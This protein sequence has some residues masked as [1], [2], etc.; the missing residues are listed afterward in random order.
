MTGPGDPRK[1]QIP[2]DN[3]EEVFKSLVEALPDAML[4]HSADRIVF[5]N[6]SCVKLI[7][8]DS[9]E[10]L[11]G[12]NIYDFV[13][14]SF[15]AEVQRRNLECYEKGTT[16]SPSENVLLALDG[17]SVPTEFTAT[18]ISWHGSPA[19]E[20]VLRN[21]RGRKLA[22]ET[23]RE[24]ERIV[25]G[26]Q[27]MIA[28]IDREYRFV[29]AN[30]AFLDYRCLTKEQVI[31]HSVLDLVDRTVFQ[32]VMK[33][34]L[35][36]CFAGN[37]VKYELRNT[38]P[39]LGE[40]DL[41][42]S[43]FPIENAGRVTGAAC[44]L[45]DV[46]DRKRKAREDRK[47][48]KR[49]EL[50]EQAGLRLGLWDW[51]LT[52]NTVFWSDESYRQSGFAPG[53]FSER[54][55]DA[56]RRVHPDDQ[57]AVANAIERVLIHG[58]S[59]YKA[60]YRLLR[61]D[62]AIRWIDA[63][64]VVLRGDAAHMIGVA[65][66]IT[67]LKKTEQSLKESEEQYLLLLNSTAEAIH[68]LDAHGNCTFCNPA[69]FRLLGYS[70]ADD[71]IGRNMHEVLHHS[72]ADGVPYPEEEC[73]IYKAFRQ[74]RSSHVT[75][76]VFWRLDGTSFP[77][78]C[79]SY[80]MWKD[81][82]IIGSVVTFLDISDRQY[83]ES[84][85]RQSEE[86]YRQLFENAPYGIYHSAFDGTLLD[87]NTAL[88]AML[89]YDSKEELMSRN[90]DHDIYLDASERRAAIER[91]RTEDRVEGLEFKWKRRDGKVIDVRVSGRMIQPDDGRTPEME[92]IVD[93]ITGRKSL[94]QQLRQAQKMESVGRLAG[95]IAHDFNNLLMVIQS[96]TELLQD[97]LPPGDILRRRTHEVMKA[98]GRAATTS[99]QPQ[100]DHLPRRAQ[101]ECRHHR[102]REDVEA[103]HR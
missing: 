55:E 82:E 80:P 18:L 32:T 98:T 9:P 94:Q 20:V 43:Y 69:C 31:G 91:C 2:S 36:E 67:N 29:I 46:T 95:G 21:I 61:P 81:G 13:H 38:Y 99:V 75:D 93:D 71:L 39:Q 6:P 30:R 96:Y 49:I 17:S 48:H 1:E 15:R 27:D 50:A 45:R 74:E 10:Q 40:R 89:G 52:S 92:V 8:A 28:V 60:Q 103:R 3:S 23:L 100:A 33:P 25:E 34:K 63:H 70:S 72:R 79:W 35:D 4:V 88:V 24:Y 57:A 37:V 66:D 26:S 11:L 19:L 44:V 62:G 65:V 42:A 64:G 51:D 54:L 7:C 41:L 73:E 90:L 68:G 85:L 86:K 78:E 56:F 87:V 47:W 101:P 53:S 97:S 58:A 77:V 14:P 22:E 102:N 83:A 12:K 59:E 76:E 16:T 5:V 84:A